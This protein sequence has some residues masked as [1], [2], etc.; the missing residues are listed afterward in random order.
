M[1]RLHTLLTLGLAALLLA[2]SPVAF[3]QQLQ[4]PVHWSFSVKKTGQGQYS[5]MADARIVDKWHIYAMQPGGDGSLIGTSM[6]FEN[7][8]KLLSQPKELTPAREEVLMDEHVRLHSGK[9]SIVATLSGKP[10]QTIKGS[11]EYQACNDR[12]CLPPKTQSFTLTLP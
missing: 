6:Q 8:V 10:G 7:G 2:C 3:A 5:V 12:M 9:A 1:Q 4:D 11:V